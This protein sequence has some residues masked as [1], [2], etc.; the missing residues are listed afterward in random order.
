MSEYRLGY[1]GE[2]AR[3]DGQTLEMVCAAWSAADA[4]AIK[5]TIARAGYVA[6]TWKVKPRKHNLY[7]DRAPLYNVYSDIPQPAFAALLGGG[8]D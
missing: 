7:G 6:R 3:I 5:A 1:D 4:R 8:D 2:Q